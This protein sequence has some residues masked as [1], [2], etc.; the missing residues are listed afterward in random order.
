MGTLGRGT[1]AVRGAGRA[2]RERED[3]QRASE[4]VQELQEDL[5]R[6]QEELEAQIAAIQQRL[7]PV[8]LVVETLSLH[9]RKGEIQVEKAILAWT[10][11]ER[12]SEG[13]LARKY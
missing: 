9:P 4:S 12:A 10:P 11:W 5:S 8:A 7:D 1:T 3:V 2:A 6:I 13:T